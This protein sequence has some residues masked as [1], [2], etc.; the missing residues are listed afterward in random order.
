[1]NFYITDQYGVTRS[2][3]FIGTIQTSLRLYG[4]ARA[5]RIIAI[6]FDTQQCT[7]QTVFGDEFTIFWSVE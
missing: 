3:L 2:V 6:N 1:M 4:L 7:Y 5:A